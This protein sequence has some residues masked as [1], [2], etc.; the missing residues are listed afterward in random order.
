M[1]EATDPARALIRAEIAEMEKLRSSVIRETPVYGFRGWRGIPFSYGRVGTITA[2]HTLD[3]PNACFGKMDFHV[4][5][6][7]PDT[8]PM[9]RRG[10][11]GTTSTFL[12]F[13][14]YTSILNGLKGD[15]Q[16]TARDPKRREIY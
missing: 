4:M 8:P 3:R 16:W 11:R 2:V 10:I 9:S 7:H 12:V 5:P 6:Q 13:G 15:L 1:T 14:K